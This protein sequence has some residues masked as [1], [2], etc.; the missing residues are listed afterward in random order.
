MNLICLHL[1][2]G[3]LL[4]VRTKTLPM[5]IKV[6]VGNGHVSIHMAEDDVSLSGCLAELLFQVAMLLDLSILLQTNFRE[7]TTNLNAI[8]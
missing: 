5:T 1:L 3:H 7:E 4:F 2:I 6:G 8:I